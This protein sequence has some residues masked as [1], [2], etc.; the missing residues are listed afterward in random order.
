M[1]TLL[2]YIMAMGGGAAVGAV[3]VGSWKA[4][5]A[6][7]AEPEALVAEAVDV[8]AEDTLAREA[9]A[10][11]PIAAPEAT[12][13]ESLVA[14]EPET[15]PGPE[16]VAAAA[17]AVMTQAPVQTAAAPGTD[18]L[19][20]VELNFQRLARIFAAM[21]PDEAAPVLAQL[22]DAQLEGILL[23]MQGRNAAPILAEMDPQRAAAVSRRV[24]GDPQ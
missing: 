3:G 23:A 17:P 18:S 11:A 14:A 20:R 16:E 12:P 5:V 15:S 1:K 6:G 9:P 2:L 4:L 8:G 22:E 21:K 19:A 7:E 24:L 10:P 13:S